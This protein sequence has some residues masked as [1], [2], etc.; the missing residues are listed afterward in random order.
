M[1]ARRAIS[2]D[3]AAVGR[4]GGRRRRA[5]GVRAGTV[6]EAFGIAATVSSS[7]PT[8]SPTWRCRPTTRV[9]AARERHR[10]RRSAL[11]RVPGDHPSAQA[12]PASWSSCSRT[13]PPTDARPDRWRGAAEE[14]AGRGDRRGAGAGPGRAHRPGHR[15]RS[16]RTGG[17][18]GRRWCSRVSTRASAPRSSRR[19]QLGIPIVCSDRAAIP[20]VVGDAAV[21]VA[22]DD[23]RRGPTR[24][25][26]ADAGREELSRAGHRRREEFT[27]AA[28]GPALADAYRRRPGDDRQDGADVKIVVLCPH[29]APDTAPTGTVMTRIVH[30]LAG[31]GHELHVVTAL[32]W[33]RAHRIETGWAG[34]WSGPSRRRGARSHACIRSLATTSRTSSG[35]RSGL[36]ASRCWPVSPGSEPAVVLPLRRRPRHVA[37]A[38]ARADR[39]IVG[40]FRRA[41]LVFNIQDVFPDAAVAPERSRTAGS[42]PWRRGSNASAITAAAAVTVLSDDLRTTWRQVQRP[43]RAA[44]RSDPELRRHRRD[45]P[46]DR[47]TAYRSELGIGDEP[48]VLYAGNIGFSQSL[49]LVSRPRPCPE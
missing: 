43:T 6:L 17:G 29:F 27:L 22:G 49:D 41:P 30:E 24:S 14:D 7:Y 37:T 46:G 19:W 40:V 45:R 10:P 15:R 1:A 34:R 28:S 3:A 47:A 48:V 32:P 36:P 8:A 25:S 9:R 42:S 16:R 35:G 23:R 21:V 5:V 44:R 4:P 18:S 39:W 26:T 12:S 2:G 31:L 20:E 13:S 33:Y 38:H 11:R